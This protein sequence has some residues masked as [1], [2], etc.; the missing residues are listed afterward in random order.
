MV[1]YWHGYVHSLTRFR[2]EMIFISHKFP[3]NWVFPTGEPADGRVPDLDS[4]LLRKENDNRI[5]D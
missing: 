4:L 5:D 1:I 3:D 2:D